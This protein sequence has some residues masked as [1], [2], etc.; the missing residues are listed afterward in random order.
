[1]VARHEDGC[2]RLRDVADTLRIT[3]RSATDVVDQLEAKNL[4]IRKPDPA[5]RRAV[6]L[7][8]TAEGEALIGEIVEVRRAQSEEFFAVL[9]P[10]EREQLSTIL[11]KIS[12]V[13]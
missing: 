11:R 4:V 9:T 3:P 2:P 6:L 12:P 13:H 5:D 10:G 8:L 1:M 7:D